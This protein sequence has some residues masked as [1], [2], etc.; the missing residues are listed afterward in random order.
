MNANRKSG[1]ALAI[2][3]AIG[4]A[5]AAGIHA[6]QAKTAPGFLLAEIEVSDIPTMQKYGA[7]MPET[8]APYN[9]QY[10]IRGGKTISLEGEPPKSIVML[11]FE[12]IEKA[13]A[14]YDSPEYQAIRPIRQ[15]AAKGRLFLVEGIAPK[16]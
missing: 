9:T 4:A 5:G 15:S 12:S 3:V 6:G 13:K 16:E 2:G 10:V 8:L 1:L 11:Q 7:K 14:W